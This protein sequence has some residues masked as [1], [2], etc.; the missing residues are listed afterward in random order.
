MIMG[1]SGCLISKGNHGKQAV[2]DL[3]K[4]HISFKKLYIIL[5]CQR[6]SAQLSAHPRLSSNLHPSSIISVQH[7]ILQPSPMLPSLFISI[8]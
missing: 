4:E 6:L 8:S 7:V 1:L 5:P 2:N 3:R